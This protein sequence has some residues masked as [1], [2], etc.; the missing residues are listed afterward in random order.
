MRTSISSY[1]MSASLRLS[2]ARMQSELARNQT[3][4]TSGRKADIGLSLGAGTGQS[5]SLRQEQLRLQSITDSNS[6]TATRLATTQTSL[7]SI[8]TGAQSLLQTLVSA[9]SGGASTQSVQTQAAGNLAALTDGLNA[10]AN[11]DYIFGGVNTDVAPIAAYGG[12]PPSAAKTA[13]DAAF[14][15]A[16]GVA[17]TSPAVKSID[18]AAM[19][20]FLDTQ[21]GALFQGA[22]WTGDWSSASDQPI[23]SRISTSELV[24]TSVSANDPA[25]RKLAQAYTMVSDLGAS[26]MSP[27]AYQ[28][29]VDSATRLVGDAL[30]RLTTL[31]ANM[32]VAQNR[33]TDA[34]ERM[35]VQMTSLKT[36]LGGLE[37]VDPY[38]ASTRMS[39]L[40]TQIQ[41][42]YSLTAQ[43]R[44]L[45]LLKYL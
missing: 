34:N 4:M 18:G 39:A 8:R 20:S 7:A 33:V 5:V 15:A 37:D 42:A 10:S 32:G 38:E 21:F 19:Q 44:D 2:V 36:Q 27:S 12:T 30:D 3:E 41:T 1:T 28:A 24:D 43:L 29:V 11:G 13:V 35:S 45:S 9:R 14:S 25:M 22:S 26:G 16:F 23:R 17:Q 31:Q 6:L 40:T